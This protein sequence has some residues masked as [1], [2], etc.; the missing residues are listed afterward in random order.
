MKIHI[1]RCN[2]EAVPS[3]SVFWY[4]LQCKE[5]TGMNVVLEILNIWKIVVFCALI[6]QNVLSVNVLGVQVL[7]FIYFSH[8][9]ALHVAL[10]NVQ[11]CFSPG[12]ISE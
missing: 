4:I 6:L 2:T 5:V 12:G 8:M 9:S 10:F 1:Y 11:S 3:L 7:M